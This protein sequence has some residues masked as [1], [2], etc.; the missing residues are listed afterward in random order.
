MLRHV[1]VSETY[2]PTNG[3]P[4]ALFP[5]P[6]AYAAPRQIQFGLRFTY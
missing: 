5:Q 6:T 1:Q 4:L 2:G 3:Q